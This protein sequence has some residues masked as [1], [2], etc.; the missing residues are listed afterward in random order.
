MEIEAALPRADCGGKKRSGHEG[1]NY[2]GKRIQ[3]GEKTR[4]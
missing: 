2:Q 4:G 3:K 1:F